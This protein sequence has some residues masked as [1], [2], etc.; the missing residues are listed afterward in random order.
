MVKY[1]LPK[2]KSMAAFFAESIQVTKQLPVHLVLLNTF[3]FLNKKIREWAARFS[4]PE[5]TCSRPL[6]APAS[7]AES[8]SPTRSRQG[9]GAQG[10][11]SG[12][13]RDTGSW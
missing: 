2:G 12:G 3:V 7:W 5:A 4:S 13:S 9:S 6:T 10:S 11:T 1:T 8:A